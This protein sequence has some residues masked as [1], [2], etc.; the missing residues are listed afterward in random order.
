MINKYYD[1]WNII[2]LDTFVIDVIEEDAKYWIACN[3]TIFYVEGGGMQ[4]DIGTINGCEVLQLKTINGHVYHLLDTKIEGNVHMCV[5]FE[6]RS[7]KVQIHSAQHLMC[8]L[9][10][11][12]YNAKT[13][14]FFYNDVEAGAEMGFDYLD[15]KI[16]KEI[17]D[18]CNYYI[19][20]DLPIEIIYPTLEEALKYAPIEKMNHEELRAVKIGDIDYNMCGCIHVPSL[21]YLQMLKIERY[22]KTT[23]GYRIYFLTGKQLLNTYKSQYHILKSSSQ[24][25]AVPIDEVA[26]GIDKVLL[27][28]KKT[29]EELEKAK[30][31]YLNLLKERYVSLNDECII[32]VFEDLDTKQLSKLASMIV[33]EARKEVYL[34]TYMNDRMHLVITHHK[35][36][37]M[38]AGEIF[39]KLAKDYD[40][41]GGGN[42]FMAQGG[43]T[44]RTDL[45]DVLKSIKSK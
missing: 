18:L 7:F 17:E 35:D 12:R 9:I 11:K 30:D 8:G 13:I 27:D 21:R 5:D 3:E 41:K 19:V 38:N 24:K 45:I 6:Q 22:E 1:D 42:A 26:V 20:Q 29:R 28:L 31:I 32:E 25:L 4:S 43:G 33:K 10:N 16:I 2:E 37:D 40:L 39:K 36:I 14:A 44:K 15:D 23:R 34:L